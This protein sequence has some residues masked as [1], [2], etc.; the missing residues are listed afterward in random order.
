M[1]FL[2]PVAAFIAVMV[3][4]D[5]SRSGPDRGCVTIVRV[6]LPPFLDEVFFVRFL[7]SVFGEFAGRFKPVVLATTPLDFCN[8][9][10]S[11]VE[12]RGTPTGTLAYIVG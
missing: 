2:L 11:G 8:F 1:S 12:P 6:R 10:V 5:F 9:F 3:A 4:A 7:A